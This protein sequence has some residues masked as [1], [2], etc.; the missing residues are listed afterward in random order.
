MDFKQIK[1]LIRLVNQT[2]LSE[3]K[4]ETENFKISLRSKD[5]TEALNKSKSGANLA[6]P[7]VSPVVHAPTPVVASAPVVSA[8]NQETGATSKESTPKNDKLITIKSPMI[9]TFYRSSSPDKPPY[10]KIGDTITKGD[11]LCI[12]EAMKLFNEIESEVNGKIV[13]I[14]LDDSSPVEYDQDLYRVELT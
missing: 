12:V 6:F 4:I 2:D 7:S 5:Y 3:L 14:L 1:E 8:P 9:G 10:V 13:E 11:V